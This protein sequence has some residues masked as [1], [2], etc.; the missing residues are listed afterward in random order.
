MYNKEFPLQGE[1]AYWVD[2]YDQ[3]N[4]AITV[5]KAGAVSHDKENG[6][7]IIRVETVA[8]AFGLHSSSHFIVD[9]AWQLQDNLEDAMRVMI[10]ALFKG[11]RSM[12]NSAF[13]KEQP[14]W[15]Y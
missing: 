4:I 15:E 1:I 12:G 9:Y 10:I 11:S 14:P 8:D 7:D 6:Y 3:D 13:Y 5:V 2:G